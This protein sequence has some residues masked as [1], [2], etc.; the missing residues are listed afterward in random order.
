MRWTN[1]R[2]GLDEPRTPLLHEILDYPEGSA[3]PTYRT[4]LF[5]LAPGTQFSNVAAAS[6]QMASAIGRHTV[7]IERFKQIGSS[8]EHLMA[9]S[10]SH[11]LTDLGE[12]AHL[13]PNLDDE[14]LSFAA[15]VAVISAFQQLKLGTPVFLGA[16]RITT[17]SSS[18]VLFTTWGLTEGH[19]F[20]DVAG[21]TQRLEEL[22]GCDWCR[23]FQIEGTNFLGLVFGSRPADAQFKEP[24]DAFM[25]QMQ[26]I[27]WSFY[28][29]MSGLVGSDGRSPTLDIRNRAALGLEELTFRYATGMD[30]AMI[31]TALEKLKTSSGYSHIELGQ[32]PSEPSL[33][34]VL[35]GDR[36]PLSGSYPFMDYTDEILREPVRGE[37]F[38][39]WA[40]GMTSSGRLKWYQWDS[41]EP[42]LLIAG[43]SGSGKSGVINNMLCQL[44]HNNHPDDVRVWLVEPK[45][46]LHAYKNL[47]HVTRFL[48]TAVTDDSPH[49]AFAALMREAIAEMR[50]RYS[51]MS[52]HDA[53]PQKLAECRLLARSD[54]AGSG[55]LNF[56]YVFIVVEECANYFTKPLAQDREGP[57]RDPV[58]RAETRPRG[59]RRGDVSDPRDA[60]PDQREHPDDVETSVPAVGV[61]G[62][63]VAGESGHHRPARVG[64]A[65]RSRPRSAAGRIP[66]CGVPR[67]VHGTFRGQ[68]QPPRRQ[69]D[70]HQRTAAE[71]KLAETARGGH[72]QPA[73]QSGRHTPRSGACHAAAACC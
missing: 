39:D 62:V 46:E 13:N 19:T 25:Q 5:L 72:T 45:N 2:L 30:F 49:E 22:L 37:P 73:G 7:V 16:E 53:E 14:T 9:F 47:P 18:L 61:A 6:R 52:A 64:E 3:S 58:A 8:Q 60:V 63:V 24:A 35:A 68:Q 44:F 71:R 15:R 66:W 33:F 40:V 32:H 48:D 67:V 57:R 29:Q 10:L 65:Q 17:P 54:P 34:V 51:A 59:T 21:H 28:M 42:H 4:L 26:T 38:T 31:E 50:R 1:A 41:E 70:D 11:E 36:D 69:S 12:A 55:H 43:A 20:G 56:P 23:P 27:D